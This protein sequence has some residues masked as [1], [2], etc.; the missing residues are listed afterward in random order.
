M[1]KNLNP[2]FSS[3]YKQMVNENLKICTIYLVTKKRKIKT[4]VRYT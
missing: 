2:H 3:G 4:I 1:R